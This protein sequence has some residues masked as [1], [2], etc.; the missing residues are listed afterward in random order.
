MK[1]IINSFIDKCIS[2]SSIPK[3]MNIKWMILIWIKRLLKIDKWNPIAIF[4]NIEK[5][6]H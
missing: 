5:L 1:T 2:T 6:N 4:F 3:D